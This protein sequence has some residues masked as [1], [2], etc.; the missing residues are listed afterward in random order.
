MLGIDIEITS[1]DINVDPT[2]N[3]IKKKCRKLGPERAKA[4][5]DEVDKLQKIGSI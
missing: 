5:N 1:H 4:V 2:F 3:P